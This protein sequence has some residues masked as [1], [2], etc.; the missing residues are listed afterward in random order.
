MNDSNEPVTSPAPE[1]K[2]FKLTLSYAL[3]RIWTTTTTMLIGWWKGEYVDFRSELEKRWANFDAIKIEQAKG[4]SDQRAKQLASLLDNLRDHYMSPYDTSNEMVHSICVR[5]AV[6]TLRTVIEQSSLYKICGI[7]T[8]SGAV[9]KLYHL[10]MSKTNSF[11]LEIVCVVAEAHTS[12]VSEFFLTSNP[13]ILTEMEFVDDMG[14]ALAKEIDMQIITQTIEDMK[15]IGYINSHVVSLQNPTRGIDLMVQINRCAGYI[16]Q[17]TSRGLGNVCIMSPTAAEIFKEST[18]VEATDAEKEANSSLS[19]QYLGEFNK[20]KY[21]V[22][23]IAP[24]DD[25]VIVTYRGSNEVDNPII[26]GL[27][28]PVMTR[29]LEMDPSLFQPKVGIHTRNAMYEADNAS[30]FY[31]LIRLQ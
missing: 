8:I 17:A 22:N 25:P 18:F 27:Y 4:L 29:G 1:L 21:Y 11:G 13:T 12:R 5:V 24:N 15:R 28:L 10:Q 19:L 14:K 3:K 23:P 26:L 6:P 9:G 31:Q 2:Y 16:G 20:I 7:Q 30:D